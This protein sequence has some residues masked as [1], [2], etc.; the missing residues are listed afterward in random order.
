M[1]IHTQTGGGT[2]SIRGKVLSRLMDQQMWI[3]LTS[4]I[5]CCPGGTTVSSSWRTSG[6]GMCITETRQNSKVRKMEG[7]NSGW[8]NGRMAILSARHIFFRN[9]SILEVH[10][11]THSRLAITVRIIQIF[12]ATQVTALILI[13]SKTEK[14]FRV[15]ISRRA[16]MESDSI[17]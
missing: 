9:T 15:F 11:T 7:N 17:I 12:K 14:S 16:M 10:N 2:T 4:H 6:I 5:A 3:N 8:R 13:P 1:F